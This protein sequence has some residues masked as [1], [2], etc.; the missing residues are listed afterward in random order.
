MRPAFSFIASSLILIACPLV[1]IAQSTPEP[2]PNKQTVA[3]SNEYPDDLV[4]FKDLT[5]KPVIK[6]KPEPGH[7]QEAKY[8]QF[9]GTGVLEVVLAS[10]GKVTNVR[11]I[12]DL[13]YGL[14][15]KIIAAS[16]KIKFTP[17]EKDGHRVS[18]AIRVEYT[19]R[20]Y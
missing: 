17:A 6:S 19:Y 9:E 10:S 14:N 1:G 13:P 4:P 16:R 7:T 8:K 15:Q 11:V 3:K 18:V 5:K 2:K 12:K 20:L